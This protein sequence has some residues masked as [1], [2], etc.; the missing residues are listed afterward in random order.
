[1][2]SDLFCRVGDTYP[3]NM[4]EVHVRAYI[5][6]WRPRKTLEGEVL[7]YDVR[8]NHYEISNIPFSNYVC[9]VH[10]RG[11]EFY[12]IGMFSIIWYKTWKD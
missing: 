3:H 11:A 8:H 7:P 1:M 10:S 6:R 4:L 9:V 2:T 12:Q 5:Y